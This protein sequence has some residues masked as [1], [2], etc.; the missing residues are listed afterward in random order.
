MNNYDIII[1]GA[2]ASGLMCASHL[3]KG[4]NTAIIDT[5]SK[6]A[7]KLKIS[8]GGKC[9]ITNTEVTTNHYDGDIQIVSSTIEAYSK[10]DLL[11]FLSAH[12]ITLEVRKNRYYFCKKSSDEIISIF[13]KLTANTKKYLNTQVKDVT[14]KDGYFII[15]TNNNTLKCKKL[16]VA[17]GGKS[18]ENLGASDIGLRIAKKFNIKVR[19]F[20]PALVGLTLQPKEFWMKKLSGLS[21]YVH[22]KIG[23]KTIKEDMLFAHKGISGPA[24]LSTSLYWKKGDITINF[25]PNN[26]I[27]KLIQNTKKKISS[28]IPLPKR[29]SIAILHAIGIEDTECKKLDKKTIQK[30]RSI[31]SYSFAPAGNFGFSKAEVSSGGINC[32]ELNHYTFEALDVKNLYFIGEVLDVTGELGGYNLQWAFSSAMVCA[33][34]IQ[35][36]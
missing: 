16:I 14:K 27:E 18:F 22:I 29:L 33:N 25:L 17:S 8:G 3:D 34:M 20:S 15:Q 31:H 5:N 23:H 10:E 6:I 2:G 21:C 4:L 12:K 9:N 32:N 30:L 11:K 26:D 24:I 13:Q 28:T 35:R 7:R 36:D 1:I 19:E